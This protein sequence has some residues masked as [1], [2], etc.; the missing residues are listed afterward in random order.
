MRTNG[1]E[2]TLEQRGREGVQYEF[3]CFLAHSWGTNN[4]T[5]NEVIQIGDKL[6]EEELSVWIDNK[7]MKYDISTDVI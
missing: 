4:A 3:D 7:N 2:T 1:K 5:H 6:V